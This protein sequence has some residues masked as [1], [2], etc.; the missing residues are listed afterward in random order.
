[1]SDEGI[2]P[3]SNSELRLVAPFALHRAEDRY[4]TKA[5]DT[6]D[7]QNQD[8]RAKHADAERVD[9]ALA[10]DVEAIATIRCSEEEQ[11]LV[12]YLKSRGATE[13]EAA[14]TVADLFADCFAAAPG[15]VSLLAKYSGAGSLRGFL[16]TAA[17]NRFIAL[18]RHLSVRRRHV[19]STLQE[20]E[21]AAQSFSPYEQDGVGTDVD[22]EVLTPLLRDAIE[23]AYRSCSVRE[24]LILRLVAG[25][26][27]SQI[28]LAGLLGWSQSKISRSLS[29]ALEKIREQ[30][31]AEVKALDPWLKL[32]WQD[33]VELCRE[34][35]NQASEIRP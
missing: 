30:V 14:D 27:V 22:R 29:S 4:K 35:L 28:K 26:G 9:R 7:D 1:M 33:V 15:K 17:F 19:E 6:A 20:N 13:T 3:S 18:K 11:R 12:A 34:S 23:Q 21:S 8:T 5:V 32:D 2:H 31:L 25:H 24:L 16:S 10:G